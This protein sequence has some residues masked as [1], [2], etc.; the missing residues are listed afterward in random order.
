MSRDLTEGGIWPKYS[1]EGHVDRGKRKESSSS[2]Q[3][4]ANIL[5]NGWLQLLPNMLSRSFNQVKR[6]L[7]QKKA[8]QVEVTLNGE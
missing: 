1:F 2:K 5:H 6:T 7:F 4:G 3:K 8:L